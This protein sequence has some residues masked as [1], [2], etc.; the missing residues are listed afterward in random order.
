MVR[1]QADAGPHV[2]LADADQIKQVLWNLVRNALEAMPDGGRLE[3]HLR[4][5]S[6]EVVL[7]VRD[8][9]R[10]MG[11]DEQ[12]RMFEPYRTSRA[13]GT[14]LGLAIVFRIVRDH[15]GDIEVRSAPQVGTEID[16]RLPLVAVAQPG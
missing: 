5:E 6:A 7:S 1:F 14:G 3:V 15:G 4:R 10:G 8:Q 16:V 13:M 12:G 2:C 9:G 11:R